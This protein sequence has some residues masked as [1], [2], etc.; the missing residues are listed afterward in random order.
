MTRKEITTGAMTETIMDDAATTKAPA[1]K[2]RP[3]VMRLGTI[4]Q[5]FRMTRAGKRWWL[6]PMMVVL[7]FLGLVLSGLQAIEYIAPFIYAIF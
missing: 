5:V 7:V 1:K 6:M 2:P 3:I 4:R